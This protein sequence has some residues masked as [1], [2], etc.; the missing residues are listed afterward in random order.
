MRL[1][2]ISDRKCGAYHMRRL[3]RVF[4]PFVVVAG[5][6]AIGGYALTGW[7]SRGTAVDPA[8][9]IQQSIEGLRAQT[10]AHSATWHLG[11]EATWT[12]DQGTGRI[13]FTF[14]DGTVA[15]ADFQIV[16][17]YDS[18]DGTFLWGWDHPSVGEP[19][20]EHARLAKEF[21]LKHALSK[22]T[23]RMVRCTE[24]EAWEFTAVAARLGNVNGAYRGPAGTTFVF[25]TF[26]EI[27]LSKRKP[28]AP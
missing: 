20:R 27:S 14:E 19:L 6:A 16:G 2:E 1:S 3:N 21:G 25:M 5:A 13:R 12:A 23:E 26:G 24:E 10:A 18:L 15:D 8:A 4:V 7:R 28:A 9:F 22:Y 11:E 17:S